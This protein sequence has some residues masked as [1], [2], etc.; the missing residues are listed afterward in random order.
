M[1]RRRTD[2]RG[3][4]SAVSS[5][6][7]VSAEQPARRAGRA[8]RAKRA[9]GGGVLRRRLSGGIRRRPP[10]RRCRHHRGYSCRIERR[11]RADIRGRPIGRQQNAAAGPDRGGAAARRVR[12]A[13][14]QD[15]RRR[16]VLG[17][18]PARARRRFGQSAGPLRDRAASAGRRA[19]C[20]PWPRARSARR[21]GRSRRRGL[22]SHGRRACLRPDDR[23]CR[24]RPRR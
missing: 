15:Q 14:V 6:R 19:P 10:Y 4:I 21:N 7:A 13:D 8:C 16:A 1:A 20:T 24:R 12:R 11:G 22:R 23:D 18:R 3:F 9:V 17:Q 2:L 5:S